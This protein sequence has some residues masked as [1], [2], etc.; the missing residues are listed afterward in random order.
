M[1]LAGIR[2]LGEGNGR[3]APGWWMVALAIGLAAF[4]VAAHARWGQGAASGVVEA[5][6]WARAQGAWAWGVLIVLQVAVCLAG[7][8]PASLVVVASGGLYG[9]W[10]GFLTASTA[11]LAGAMAS[12][13]AGRFVFRRFLARRIRRHISLQRMD[14]ELERQGWR[15][16]ALLRMCPFFP[17]ALMS[18]AFGLSGIRVRD[19]LIGNVGTLPSLFV[20]TYTGT[21]VGDLTT[22]IAHGQKGRDP[23]QWAVLV[24]G[25]GATMVLVGIVG[26]WAYGP[27]REA[28]LEK[29]EPR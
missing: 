2:R 22:F 3:S 29:Q 8:V 18:Y 15:L 9:L 26:R 1:G 10:F 6:E 23:L 14:E 5:V 21:V 12:F 4:V 27:L 20:L 11:T 25:L 19:F 24:L 7:V 17:F 16:A 13:V 28:G